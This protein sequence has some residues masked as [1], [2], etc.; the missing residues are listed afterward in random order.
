MYT[1]FTTCI[2]NVHTCVYNECICNHLTTCHVQCIQI[3]YMYTA[4]TTLI[5]HLQHLLH[6]HTITTIFYGHQEYRESAK[7]LSPKYLGLQ[8]T[9]ISSLTSP[10]NLKVRP[11]NK[12]TCVLSSQLHTVC[13]SVLQ[14]V[15]VWCSVLQCVAVCC[16]VLQ[17]V[18][19]CCSVLQCVAACC[20]VL[21]CVA[22]CCR[23]LQ[24]A[25]MV[26]SIDCV[27]V[28]CN[29]LQCVVCCSVLQSAAMLSSVHIPMP[30]SLA[31]DDIKILEGRPYRYF[32]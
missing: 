5:L 17:C 8:C 26:S 20:S 15:A 10:P 9:H 19:V 27:A 16:S 6:V 13:C 2:L 1:A 22:V 4:F 24:C 14:C 3:Y 11:W 21:Q 23:V 29:V 30:T 25:A 32:T 28:C 31:E 18:A 7:N 12:G